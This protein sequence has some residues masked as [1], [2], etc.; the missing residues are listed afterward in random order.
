MQTQ[1]SE[2]IFIL[3]HVYFQSYLCLPLDA[4]LFSFLLSCIMCSKWHIGPT[5]RVFKVS[6]VQLSQRARDFPG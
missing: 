3:I 1:G 4:V 6:D 2:E 5:G